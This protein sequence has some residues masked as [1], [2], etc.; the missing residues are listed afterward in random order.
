ML[1]YSVE[2]HEDASNAAPEER[3]TV[4]DVRLVLQQQNV[5][6]HLRGNESADHLTIPLYSLAE[7][8]AHDWWTLFGG[9]DRE[10]SLIKHRSGYAVPDLRMSFDGTVF[11]ISAHQCTYHNPDVRFWAGP[12]EVM[13]R[14]PAEAI[15]SD[16]VQ[17]VLDRL[18]ARGVLGT[19]AALR[20]A[21][22]QKSRANPDEA[23]FCEAAGALGRDPYQIDEQSTGLIAQAAALFEG[24][25][26][27]EFLAG[28]GPANQPDLMKWVDAV[29][30]R[31]RY[32][33]RVAELRRVAADTVRGAPE[34]DFEKSWALG[35]RRARAMR[36]VLNLR[37]SDRF[38]SF[39][40]LAE[41]L[42]ASQSYALAGPVDGLRALRSDRADGAYI[43]MRAHGNSNEA[44]AAHLFSF[45]RAVGDVVCFPAEDRAPIN[46]LHSAYRQEAGRAFAAEF[47]APIDELR[48]MREGGR[49]TVS[50][51]DEFGVSTA[52][53][54]RQWEN[55]DRIEE[56][57]AQQPA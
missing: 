6:L 21:R 16:F 24:E 26:L 44:K 48:S 47:L 29:E 7:G 56:V 39:R 4:A 43:H 33:A 11:Q 40:T 15:L 18:S 14:D 45:T 20:W 34:R 36:R 30:R 13:S 41:R 55:R 52:V 32:K 12:T 46:E 10:L 27:L 35:Y 49:D 2:W 25:A 8:L 54:E 3:A 5:S 42:G 57:R 19:S 31:P 17:R 9:R 51:A 50:I 22:V 1:R 53:I 23:V 28:A 38:R 37:E